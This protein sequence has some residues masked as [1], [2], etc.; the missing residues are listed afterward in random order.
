MRSSD[1][2]CSDAEN[3]T[4]DDASASSSDKLRLNNNEFCETASSAHRGL[5]QV[6]SHPDE[7]QT[8]IS[9]S[10]WD[11]NE[12]PDFSGWSGWTPVEHKDDLQ[13]EE[14]TTDSNAAMEL[15]GA[16][17][18]LA[19]PS[20]SKSDTNRNKFLSKQNDKSSVSTAMEQNSHMRQ[21]FKALERLFTPKELHSI[22]EEY[23]ECVEEVEVQ[24]DDNTLPF[25]N[26]ERLEQSYVNLGGEVSELETVLPIITEVGEMRKRCEGYGQPLHPYEMFLEFCVR[27]KSTVGARGGFLNEVKRRNEE[28]KQRR[29]AQINSERNRLKSTSYQRA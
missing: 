8:E 3:E 29:E 27:V 24:K 15:E 7:A 28:A 6:S 4:L 11:L 18:I 9:E 13:S 25:L 10:G 5:L 21:R 26:S 16:K 1:D 12:T 22:I 20:S 19:D 23:K 2:S 17:E 14:R